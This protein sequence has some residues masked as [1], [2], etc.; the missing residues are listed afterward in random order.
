MNYII[1]DLEATCWDQWEKNDNETIEI[2]AVKVSDS[3][4]IIDEFETFIQPIK[5][6]KLS[7]CCKDLTSIEQSDVD[8]AP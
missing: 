4:E 6:P 1:F 5:Y 7:K 2:G 8:A 3:K